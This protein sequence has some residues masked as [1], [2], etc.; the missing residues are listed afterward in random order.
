M[1]LQLL[2]HPSP[3]GIGPPCPV[4]GV[5]R[6]Q[7]LHAPGRAADAT[8]SFRPRMEALPFVRVLLMGSPEGDPEVR[9]DFG[10]MGEALDPAVGLEARDRA[11]GLGA[12][13]PVQGGERL[14]LGIDRT[15]ADHQRMPSPASSNHGERDGRL[16][17]EL[18]GNGRAIGV[19]GYFRLFSTER[20]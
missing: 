18:G 9:V 20:L 1:F 10:S 3:D 2:G 7:A 6:V 15:I 16:P 19:A 17:P 11:D 12:R 5:V 13:Q 8:P 4:I 14:A